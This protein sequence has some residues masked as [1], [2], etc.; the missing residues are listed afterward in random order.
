MAG[1]WFM[2]W[3]VWPV[4]LVRGLDGPHGAVF[5]WWQHPR[6]DQSMTQLVIMASAAHSM[7]YQVHELTSPRSG[8]LQVEASTGCPVTSLHRSEFCHFTS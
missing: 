6:V 1:A 3:P 7:T 2:H 4:W 8:N 5:C